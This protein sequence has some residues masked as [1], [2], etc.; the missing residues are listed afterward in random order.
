MHVVFTASEAV[1]WSK[2][3]GLGDVAGS[4]PRH[5][6]DHHSVT[7][8]IPDYH[9]EGV[10]RPAQARE[11]GT[12]SVRL[13]DTTYGVNFLESRLTPR[14]RVVWVNQ[15]LLFARRYIYGDGAH[16]YPD[17]FHRFLV[18]QEAV[19]AWIRLARFR[20]D[21]VHCN[22]W[23]TALLPLLLQRD[24]PGRGRPKTL[25]TIHNLG[26]QGIF[27]PEL[28]PLLHLPQA[29]FTPDTLEF[30]GSI[31]CLKG[32]IVYADA[33]NTVS[34]TYARE[35][36][37]PE[38]GAGLEG[39]LR[40]YS[41]KV[42][43]I[44]NGADYEVWNPMT[45]PHLPAHYGP[46]EISGKQTCK[47][48]LLEEL[49][50]D[51]PQTSPLAVSVTRLTRQKGTDLLI[52]ALERTAPDPVRAVVLGTGD[53]ALERRLTK[54]ADRNPGV[55]FIPRFDEGLAHRLQAAADLFLMPS[56]YEPC[57][58]AQI[59]AMRYGTLPVVRRT[60]GLADTVTDPESAEPGSGFLFTPPRASA[61]AGTLERAVGT[62]NTPSRLKR[63]RAYAMSREFSWD[64]SAAEYLELYTHITS[65]GD[66]S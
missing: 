29:C 17:N 1:P 63:M 27:P 54:L 50:L 21:L 4:L 20:V 66:I 6:A 51:W 36:M 59:Y 30:F 5:L 26:Y 44:L 2:T 32:G 60:G 48:K 45:D 12:A 25:L 62:I 58:L 3:G 37:E 53:P 47:R 52:K 43:G 13:G 22:D 61:L 15:D 57:G 40:R 14:L 35:I 46:E 24:P 55:H 64:R 49:N 28:F 16:A 23:Q 10:T 19:A 31:N 11:S 7:L 65:P 9:A 42:S 41:H 18:F 34:P 33:V 8:I 56:L 38:F 39:V